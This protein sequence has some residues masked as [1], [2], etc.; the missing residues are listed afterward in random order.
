M[1]SRSPSA[2]PSLCSVCGGL[3]IRQLKGFHCVLRI[4]ALCSVSGGPS[5]WQLQGFDCVLKMESGNITDQEYSAEVIFF[6]DHQAYLIFVSF[7]SL[8]LGIPLAWNVLW[9]LKERFSVQSQIW[10]RF[11][12]TVIVAWCSSVRKLALA[13]QIATN[14][15]GRGVLR[16][17]LLQQQIKMLCIPALCLQIFIAAYPSMACHPLI[18]LIL[19]IVFLIVTTNRSV[20][21]LSV[22]MGRYIQCWVY[23]GRLMQWIIFPD[24]F[25][26][27]RTRWSHSWRK[28]PSSRVL[29][30]FILHCLE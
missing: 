17:L 16:L 30:G 25:I 1:K 8:I 19:E 23:V 10:S 24:C 21:T 26:S 15:K 9:H 29:H 13:F 18:C 14:A 3:S 4:P 11:A 27:L 12:V 20:S 5:V 22:A 28:R 6:R 7:G 2:R